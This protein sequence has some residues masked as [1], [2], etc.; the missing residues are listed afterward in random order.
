M[1]RPLSHTIQCSKCNTWPISSSIQCLSIY[2]YVYTLEHKK[3][4]SWNAVI[5]CRARAWKVAYTKFYMG[6]IREKNLRKSNKELAWEKSGNNRNIYCYYYYYYYYI[7][8]DIIAAFTIVYIW[9]LAI[10][11]RTFY[12]HCSLRKYNVVIKGPYSIFIRVFHGLLLNCL[13]IL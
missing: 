3:Q 8:I 6:S 5:M 11:D 12:Y 2:L 1:S 4:N 7:V 9:K 10:T 13:N